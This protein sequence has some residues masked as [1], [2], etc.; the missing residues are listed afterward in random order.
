M[1]VYFFN[2]KNLGFMLLLDL[3]LLIAVCILLCKKLSIQSLVSLLQ[4]LNLCEAESIS[5]LDE[6]ASS[7]GSLDLAKSV[8][9]E[10]S[11]LP[12]L[13]RMLVVISSFLFL[14]SPLFLQSLLQLSSCLLLI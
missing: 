7:P 1:E 6:V 11:F 4:L 13:S 5:Y 3:V 9:L 12:I 10:V 14:V 2:V 8:A